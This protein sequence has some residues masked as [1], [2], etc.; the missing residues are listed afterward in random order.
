MSSS[1]ASSTERPLVVDLDGTLIN[2]DLLHESTLKIIR[3]HPLGALQLPFHLKSGKSR[4]KQYLADNVQ[5]MPETLPYNEPFLQWLRSQRDH[6]RQLILCTASNQGFAEDVAGFLGIFDDVIASDSSRN[7]KGD[8][9]AEILCERFGKGG[10]DYAGD[11]YSDLPVWRNSGGA[12]LVNTPDKLKKTVASSDCDIV[13]IFEKS[14]L[15]IGQWS[16]A[17]RVQQWLKNLL[18]FAPVLAAHRI[19]ETQSLGLLIVAFFAF[20]FVASAT[21]L[22]N[23]LLDLESDR[24]HPRKKSRLLA[25]G[26]ISIPKAI[27]MAAGLLSSGLFLG[28]FI[29]DSFF[30]CLIIYLFITCTY[31]LILKRVTLLD[32]MVLAV[33]YTLRIIAGAAAIGMGLSFWLL[34]FSAFLFTSLALIKRYA[35][36]EVQLLEGREKVHGRG[37]LTS[38]APLLQTLGVTSGFAAVLV[39]SLYLNS[40]EV[41]VLYEVPQV[42]WGA[43]LVLLYWISW[44]WM[45]A[46]RGLMH[47]DPLVFAIKDKTSLF[48]GAVFLSILLLGGMLPSW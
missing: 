20:S 6:G 38:D 27:L 25:A 14:K 36:L 4:L 12:I 22:V 15:T 42:V 5:L 19:T 3:E 26:L 39:L 16:R 48:A 30:L 28:Y 7:I 18:L 23:D 45:Q 40:D 43:V 21:Y 37:Y 32:C 33:L 17:I 34:A 31:S 44:M 10:F 1:E 11:S 2:T 24:L 29:S 41:V 47:D 13:E 46:H 35:E 9:K 8:R